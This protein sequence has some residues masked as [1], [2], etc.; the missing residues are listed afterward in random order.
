[1]KDVLNIFYFL[2]TS[3]IYIKLFL[4]ALN[5]SNYIS[6]EI[7]PIPDF[8]AKSWSRSDRLVHEGFPAWGN[9]D[10]ALCWEIVDS[11]ENKV[12]SANMFASTCHE[13]SKFNK[14]RNKKQIV[15]SSAIKNT[16]VLT[17]D[18]VN[19]I[20]NSLFNFPDM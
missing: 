12:V 3:D 8:G 14:S 4:D 17:N 2:N 5:R 9:A 18:P 20:S 16:E 13:W 19:Q 6:I 11:D 1:M 15:T 7:K 10:S